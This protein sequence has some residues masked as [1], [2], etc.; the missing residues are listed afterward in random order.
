MISEIKTNDLAEFLGKSKGWATNIKK[1]RKKL[2]PKDVLRV[3]ERF[4]ISPEELRP[5]I[6]K[7]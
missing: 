7:K 1:G 4:G 2:P 3:S 5:D 6:F